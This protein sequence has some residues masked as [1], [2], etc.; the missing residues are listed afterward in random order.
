MSSPTNRDPNTVVDNETLP[1]RTIWMQ[2]YIKHKRFSSVRIRTLQTAFKYKNCNPIYECNHNARHVFRFISAITYSIR[3]HYQSTVLYTKSRLSPLNHS[4]TNTEN[5]RWFLFVGTEEHPTVK[6]N[7]FVCVPVHSLGY[8]PER[9]S[10]TLI[11]GL[12]LE[13]KCLIRTKSANQFY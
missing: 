4:N 8:Q 7:I 3:L 9:S 5:Q 2:I 1:T 13:A 12:F 10:N 11:V 6:R